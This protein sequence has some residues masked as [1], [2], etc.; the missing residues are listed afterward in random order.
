MALR[1]AINL[2]P[3]APFHVKQCPSSLRRIVESYVNL[4]KVIWQFRDRFIEERLQGMHCHSY[5][6]IIAQY[7]LDIAV[8]VTLHALVQTIAS[9]NPAPINTGGPA[10]IASA[11]VALG[12]T[13]TNPTVSSPV[14]TTPSIPAM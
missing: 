1:R 3:N 5:Y 11:P 8:S 6:R 14:V 10:A 4:L 9:N 2:P 12:S 7:V 13:P